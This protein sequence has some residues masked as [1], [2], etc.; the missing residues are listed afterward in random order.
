MG[1]RFPAGREMEALALTNTKKIHSRKPK[2]KD[3]SFN[4]SGLENMAIKIYDDTADKALTA[5]FVFD[6]VASALIGVC[7]NYEQ[8]NGKTEF[9]FAG[10][11]MS[12]S[13]IK[14]RI[15]EKFSASFADPE[16]SADNAV[17]IAALTM[18]AYNMEKN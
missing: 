3:L 17:G 10:G 5:A 14:N 15:T 16:M 11:V 7:E 2:I 9:V 13:I 1:L 18:L 12:N 6:Y 4:L 8:K